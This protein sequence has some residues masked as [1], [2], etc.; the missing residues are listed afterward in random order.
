MTH[1]PAATEMATATPHDPAHAPMTPARRV[2]LF[3]SHLL[4]V[5]VITSVSIII[6][7][8]VVSFVHHPEYLRHHS[9]LKA[10][11]APDDVA[12][13]GPTFPHT[14]HDVLTGLADFRGQSIITVG[15][16]LLI[17]TPV[18]RVAV[19]IFGFVYEHD[20]RYV[21]I[22]SIVLTLLLLSFVLG[23]VE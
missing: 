16:L 11:T 17:A 19:S 6:V 5:G 4:R 18:L 3:I 8:M 15:L 2:E 23:K 1:E 12:V 14:L 21:V 22:T 9:P 10:L 20:R 13:P 7:G